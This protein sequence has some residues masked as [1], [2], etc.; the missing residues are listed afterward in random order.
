MTKVELT[1]TDVLCGQAPSEVAAYYQGGTAGVRT[2]QDE[3]QPRPTAGEVYGLLLDTR[4][5]THFIVTGELDLL[6]P[7]IDGSFVAF[8]G[9][10]LLR[11][12]LV[13]VCP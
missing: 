4:A 11:S 12:E 9:T 2:D 6:R 7:Q 3:Y 8:D 10:R 13:G 1:V 5:G